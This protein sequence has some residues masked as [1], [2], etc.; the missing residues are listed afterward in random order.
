MVLRE[1]KTKTGGTRESANENERQKRK[2]K[3]TPFALAEYQKISLLLYFL[4]RKTIG[5]TINLDSLNRAVTGVFPPSCSLIVN[6]GD[7][8]FVRVFRKFIDLRKI[9]RMTSPDR[10]S[11]FSRN[12]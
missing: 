9:A 6:R 5:T 8:Y 3:K 11:Y 4:S 10:M 12:T 2:K 7:I 1:R